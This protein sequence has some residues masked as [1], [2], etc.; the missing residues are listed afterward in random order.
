[1][2]R[3]VDSTTT[4]QSTVGGIHNGVD[5]L[6]GDVADSYSNPTVQKSSR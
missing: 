4:H 2:N 5:C 6:L 3:A 1:M